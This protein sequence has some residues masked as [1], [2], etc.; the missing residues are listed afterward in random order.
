M[1]EAGNKLTAIQA[2]NIRWEML[3]G[4]F[5]HQ[6]IQSVL[7][8][9][10]AVGENKAAFPATEAEWV[11][12]IDDKYLGVF[13]PEI[14][15]FTLFLKQQQYTYRLNTPTLTAHEKTVFSIGRRIKAVLAAQPEQE[16]AVVNNIA[17]A[18]GVAP[19]MIYRVA[20]GGPRV[21]GGMLIKMDR[22]VRRVEE[23][24]HE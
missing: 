14:T 15:R 18:S 5:N 3:L 13:T 21:T 19:E 9:F 1:P 6:E 17:T 22:A 20:T 16:Q 11:A 8:K 24:L 7:S 2:A 12:F 10:N 23:S 4:G